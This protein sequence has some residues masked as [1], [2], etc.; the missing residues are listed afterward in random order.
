MILGIIQDEE[1]N[2]AVTG[3]PENSNQVN[4]LSLDSTLTKS[5][6]VFTCLVEVSEGETTQFEVVLNTFSKYRKFYLSRQTVFITMN[7]HLQVLSENINFL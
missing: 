6:D 2:N 7:H 5:D 3:T 4:Y 1:G